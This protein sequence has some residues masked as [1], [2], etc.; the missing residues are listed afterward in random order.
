VAQ[1]WVRKG[2]KS[3]VVRGLQ[4][5]PRRSDPRATSLLVRHPPARALHRRSAA[6]PLHALTQPRSAHA[7][8]GDQIPAVCGAL[9]LHLASSVI[10]RC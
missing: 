5:L 6:L 8:V 7:G 1:P 9:R 3:K 4:Q 2:M 10:L